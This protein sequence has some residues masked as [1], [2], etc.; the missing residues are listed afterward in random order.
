MPPAPS[1]TSTSC[2]SDV[3]A[4]S[5]KPAADFSR[6]SVPRVET[7]TRS[8]VLQNPSTQ[9]QPDSTH[10]PP[11]YNNEL[12]VQTGSNDLD[13][14]DPIRSPTVRN[15][16][17]IETSSTPGHFRIA[18]KDIPNKKLIDIVLKNGGG[19]TATWGQILAYIQARIAPS[20]G[21]IGR[22]PSRPWRTY[23]MRHLVSA[24]AESKALLLG[25][26]APASVP[27][28]SFGGFSVPSTHPASPAPDSPPAD[29]LLFRPDANPGL[30]D[31]PDSRTAP[32]KN[33]QESST[34]TEQFT[35]TPVDIVKKEPADYVPMFRPR[36]SEAHIGELFTRSTANPGDD[37]VLYIPL[38]TPLADL[39][40]HVEEQHSGTC[41]SILAATE[42]MRDEEV[43]E[44]F[45]KLS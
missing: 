17:D 44:W 3:P 12:D 18:G 34:G 22:T 20:S 9:Q 6:A 19:A 40:R 11:P 23:Y 30:D 5:S 1:L 7:Q 29:S 15:G 10:F 27:T 43:V 13:N 45:K 21:T 39:A 14:V 36:L 42:G 28:Q 35:D 25:S 37:R 32:D 16:M 38:E 26:P 31:E 24:E 8:S 2:P 41:A 4:L 33:G